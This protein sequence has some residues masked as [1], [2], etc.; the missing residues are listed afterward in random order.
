MYKIDAL[1][2]FLENK[3]EQSRNSFPSSNIGYLRRSFS[4]LQDKEAGTQ[5]WCNQIVTIV[6]DFL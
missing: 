3:N 1:K 2:T 6:R 5:V 4:D